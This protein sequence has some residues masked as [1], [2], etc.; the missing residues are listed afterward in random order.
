VAS[1]SR[2]TWRKGDMHMTVIVKPVPTTS[3]NIHA[4]HHYRQ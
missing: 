3:G 2:L 4:L 1:A